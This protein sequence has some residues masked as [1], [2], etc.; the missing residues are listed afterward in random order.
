MSHRHSLI[1][2]ALTVMACIAATGCAREELANAPITPFT[3]DI[4]PSKSFG[5]TAS[6]TMAYNKPGD[7]YV[8]LTNVSN[9]PQAVW[10]TWNSWGYQ[11]IYFKFAMAD[12]PKS[13][14]SMKQLDFTRNGPSTFVIQPKEHQVYAIRLNEKWEAHPAVRKADEMP[15][16][17]QA[18][19]DVPMTAEAPQ[20]NVWTGHVE[21]KTYSLVLRQW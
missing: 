9:E 4:V 1:I 11:T 8:V 3:L 15:I 17:V 14:V 16:K 6:I 21:S 20:H 12:G 2:A 13:V 18:I 10:E 19:Y 7:F 5:D